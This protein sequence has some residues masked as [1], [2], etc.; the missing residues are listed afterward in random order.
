MEAEYLYFC[1]YC[2]QYTTSEFQCPHCGDY[3]GLVKLG[4]ANQL[5][6]DEL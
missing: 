2:T 1:Q 6:E 5:D 4:L 3:K